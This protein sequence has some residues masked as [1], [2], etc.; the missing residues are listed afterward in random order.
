MTRRIVPI[1]AVVGILCCTCA[2]AQTDTGTVDN[3]NPVQ[4]GPQPAYTYP[5]TTPSLDFLTG[6]IENSGI[7]LG[8]GAGFSFDSNGFPNTNTSEQRWLYNITPSIRVQQFLPKFSWDISYAGGLQVYNQ[9]TGPA[10]SNSNLFS[11]SAGAGFIWQ[12]T[13]HWQVLANDSYRYSADPFDAFLTIPGS[14]VANNPNAVAYVPLTQSTTN[15]AILTLTDQLTKRDTLSFTGTEN[16]RRTSNYNLVTSVPF[17]DL[18]SYGGRFAYNHELS[19]TLSL[20]A[21]YDY[22]SLDFGKGQERSGIQTIEATVSYQFR[23]NMTLTGWI[24][25]QHTSSVTSVTV[26]N[27]FPPPA[28][29]VLTSRDSLWST[30]LGFNFGWQSL[31]N[32]L[33]AG[34]TRSVSDG[35]GITATSEVNTANASYSRKLA[36]KW[37]GVVGARYLKSTSTDVA[38]RSFDNYFINVSVIYQISKTFSATADYVRIHQVESNAF[39]INPGIYNDNRVGVSISY[40]W[41]HPLGR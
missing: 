20:G 16:L 15:N 30:A 6:S 35:G 7:T 19:P 31:R 27:P 14:P 38:K 13:R 39:V 40:R 36:A 2:W 32:S 8:V 12:F 26:V 10:S 41:T 11:Q 18:K 24:G 22:N 33:R 21:G 25:P 4:P 1:L 34:Y 17:Y 28:L 3:T 23:P 9:I 37:S 29:L 5:D